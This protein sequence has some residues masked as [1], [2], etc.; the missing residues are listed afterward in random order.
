[1]QSAI[2]DK[3]PLH[4][5]GELLAGLAES[6][7]FTGRGDEATAHLERIVSTMAGTAYAA[8]AQ[9]WKDAPAARAQTRLACQTCHG[10]GTLTARMA[11]VAGR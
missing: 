1:M 11:E 10:P 8:R 5:K 2:V 4:M 7:Q 6:A 9:Q 3:L